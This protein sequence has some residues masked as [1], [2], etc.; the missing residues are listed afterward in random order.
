MAEAPHTVRRLHLTAAERS[1]ELLAPQDALVC[2]QELSEQLG[3]NVVV[4]SG[5]VAANDAQAGASL[6]DMALRD[7][8]EIL[9]SGDGVDGPAARALPAEDSLWV[10]CAQPVP[11]LPVPAFAE[12][13][14]QTIDGTIGRFTER[15][16]RERL[17]QTLEL[18]PLSA[19]TRKLLAISGDP[20]ADARDLVELIEQDAALAARIV[21]WANSAFYSAGGDVTTI[22]DAVVRVIGFDGVLALAMGLSVGGAIPSP[23]LPA[24]GFPDYWIEALLTASVMENLYRRAPD[25]PFDRGSAYLSGL[26]CNFGTLVLGHTFPPQYQRIC[27]LQAAN[28][29]LLYSHCDVAVVGMDREMLAAALLAGWDMP[30]LIT[31]AIREQHYEQTDLPLARLVYCARALLAIDGLSSRPNHG[32]PLRAAECLGLTR[33]DLEHT[34][35]IVRDGSDELAVLAAM[36]ARGA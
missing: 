36:F 31:Q 23:V 8:P 4:L 12:L 10:R 30:L 13:E 24:H 29:H 17:D 35:T 9:V 14:Q 1:Y 25:L 21:G 27:A 2:P 11:P 33:D 15:R 32:L 16:I 22:H 18:P 5:Q 20:D 34:L 19:T 3:G 26:L 6:V 7:A 28:R